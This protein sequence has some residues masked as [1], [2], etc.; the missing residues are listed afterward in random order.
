[1]LHMFTHPIDTV[2]PT[3]S[4]VN[5]V[6]LTCG[7]DYS[8]SAVAVPTVTDNAD[9]DPSLTLQDQPSAQCSVQRVWTAT[10]EAGNTATVTQ[11]ITFIVPQAPRIT[12][13]SQV[14]IP[15]GSVE[16]AIQNAAHTDLL[17]VH[18][19]GRPLTVT[20]NDST[21]VDRCGFTFTRTWRVQD[22]CG[23]TSTF[24]QNIRVLSLQL[25]GGPE[26]GQVNTRLDE[27]LVWPQFPGA[28]SYEVYVWQYGTQRPGVPTAVLSTR[29][30][31]PSGNYAPGTRYLWQIEYVTGVNTTVPSPIWGFETQPFADLTVT[32]ITVPPYAFSGQDLQLSWTVSNIGNLSSGVSVFYDG[33][34]MGPTTDFSE[35][36]RVRTIQQ[37]RFVDP[38]DG[39]MSSAAVN[40]ENSDIGNFYLFVETDLYGHV[41]PCRAT[42]L[43]AEEMELSSFTPSLELS[44]AA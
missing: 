12:A 35:S 37:S 19:C 3:I 7:S 13:P 39:Y 5:N 15:C 23:S 18:P 14:D 6:S 26:N 16:D 43:M 24:M 8:L 41:S 30:Y 28:Y 27:P 1:M 17:V 11:T 42:I 10:D 21:R 36:R 33:V 38:Q 40:L 31:R 34:S 22:D 25:P 44:C 9:P 32:G 2:P 20:F 4:M 29:T